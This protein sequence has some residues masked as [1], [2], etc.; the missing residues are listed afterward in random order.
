[1]ADAGVAPSLRNRLLALVLGGVA[2]AWIGAAVWAYR[3]ARHETNE[4]LDGYLVQAAA[5]LVA[6]AGDDLGELDIEHAPQLHR[7]ARRVAF[8]IWER[9]ETLRVHSANAPDRR[10]SRRT[11]GFDDVEVDGERWRVFSSYDTHRGILVQVGEE[12]SARD[13]ITIAVARGLATPLVIALPILG[14]LLWVAVTLGLAPLAA[15]GRAVARREPANLAP[16]E[17]ESPPREV[18]PLVASLNALFERVQASME[19]ERRFTADAAHEL[20]TPIAALRAQAEV[21]LGADDAAQRRRAL[22]GVIAGCDR[23]AHLVDQLLTLA[24]LDPSGATRPGGNADLAAVAREVAAVHAQAALERGI[25]LSV[26][27][28]AAAAVAADPTMLRILLRNLV[29]NAVRYTAGHGRTVRI[30]V[31]GGASPVC[32]IVDDGPGI[33]AD[34]RARLGERFHR[35]EGTDVPGSGLGLSIVLRIAKLGGANVTFATAPG[36]RGLGV[37]V[38]FVAPSGENQP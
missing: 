21:A 26:E 23:A 9:G 38:R 10:L 19:H 35:L 17:V 28:P 8:Q 7:Y 25:D 16:L 36:G 31:A 4:L 5:L 32:R 37:T 1:V 27:A 33:A 24:R 30:E 2:I 11:D 6:Q 14:I 20:R 34:E 29:D 3:D 22:E 12:R 13:K 18:A 15:L